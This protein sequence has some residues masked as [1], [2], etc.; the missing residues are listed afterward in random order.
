MENTER[1]YLKINTALT[2]ISMTFP[3]GNVVA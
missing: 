1:N 2:D 3:S